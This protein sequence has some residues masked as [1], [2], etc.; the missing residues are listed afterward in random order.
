MK[1][2]PASIKAS[3]DSVFPTWTQ[4]V[5]HHLQFSEHVTVSSVLT[6]RADESK[7]SASMF[8]KAVSI[9]SGSV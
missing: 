7:H 5:R 3:V 2:L 1:V 9:H 8:E 6:V 4:K